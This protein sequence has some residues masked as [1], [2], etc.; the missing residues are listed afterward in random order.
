MLGRAAVCVAA[1]VCLLTAASDSSPKAADS[2]RR[3]AWPF[4][5]DAWEA[6]RAWR[7]PASRCGSEIDVYVRPKIGFCNSATGVADDDE[8]D[9]VSDVDL[10]SERFTPVQPGSPIRIAE[11]AGRARLYRLRMPDGSVRAVE[12]IALSRNSD[13]VVALLSGG[14]ASDQARRVA[15]A[16]LAS[17]AV[18]TWV[19]DTLDGR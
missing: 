11:L 6:G 8:V 13:L 4:P 9:R 18:M 10:I 3:I 2:W 14:S 17:D 7:C 5:R 1:A 16:F 15:H 19:R 12:G